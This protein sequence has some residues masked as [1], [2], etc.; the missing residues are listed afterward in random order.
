[1]CLGLDKTEDG[2]KMAWTP[3]SEGGGLGSGPWV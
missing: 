3:G 1:M 2:K